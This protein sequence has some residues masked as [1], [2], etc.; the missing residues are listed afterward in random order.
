MKKEDLKE[1][2]SITNSGKAYRVTKV[3]D[4]AFYFWSVDN[5]HYCVPIDLVSAFELVKTE[6]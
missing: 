5:I 2:K 4:T 6:K 3:T 1:G